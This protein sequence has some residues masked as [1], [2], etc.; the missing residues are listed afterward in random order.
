MHVFVCVHVCAV[1]M[2]VCTCV[3]VCVWCVCMCVFRT[4]EFVSFLL[5]FSVCA[6][7]SVYVMGAYVMCMFLYVYVCF[8]VSSEGFYCTLLYNEN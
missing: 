8:P 4:S 1:C 7:A 2:G 6:C 5:S 3:Y